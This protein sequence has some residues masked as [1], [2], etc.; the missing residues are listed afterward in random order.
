MRSTSSFTLVELLITITL[1]GIM[2][3]TV[4]LVINP[5]QLLAQGRDVRRIGD[6]GSIN[7]AVASYIYQGPGATGLGSPNVVYVSL[8]DPT[9]TGSQTSTCSSLNLPALPTGWTYNCVSQQ[10]LF[11]TNGTGWMPVNLSR[12]PGGSP[13]SA[14]PVDPTNSPTGGEYYTYATNGANYELTAYFESNK[15]QA[16]AAS[17]GGVDPTTYEVGNNLALTPFLHGLVGYW[18]FNNAA[19]GVGAVTNDNSGWANNGVLEDATST[20]TG[21][22][23]T[24]SGCLSGGC[25]S[26]DG[27]DDYINTSNTLAFTNFTG[28]AWVYLSAAPSGTYGIFVSNPSNP[29]GTGFRYR[30]ESTGDVWLLMASSSYAILRTNNDIVPVGQWFF[31]TVVG[32]SGSSMSIYL[33][34]S[35]VASQS[36]NQTIATPTSASLIGTSWSPSQENF[37]GLIDNISVYNIALSPTQVQAIYNA[38]KPQ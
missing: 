11:N 38:E 5:A 7:Q 24:T 29:N 15:Y 36:T 16:T 14:L 22:T 6:L 28:M 21:P 37:N 19:L 17:D 35:L 13:I 34:G 4:V 2:A 1:I 26:F 12:I 8:P 18:N 33:N 3:A 32:N 31:I 20:G 30:I 23:Y 27:S 25:Y 9:L 10:D